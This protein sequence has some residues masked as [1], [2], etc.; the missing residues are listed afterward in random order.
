LALS[1][2]LTSRRA[3]YDDGQ[4]ARALEWSRRALELYPDDMSALVN[5]A[6]LRAR[7]GLKDEALEL[8]ER[9]FACGRGKRDWIEHDPD[10]DLLRIRS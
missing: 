3:L 6:C 5:G 9:V 1:V 2:S 7:E 10:Y 8:L 4:K